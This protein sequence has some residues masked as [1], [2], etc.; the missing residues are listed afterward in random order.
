MAYLKEDRQR[1][2]LA[3]AEARTIEGTAALTGVP[4]PTL[5][6]WRQKD[7]W[8][9]RLEMEKQ[10]QADDP[11]GESKSLEVFVDQFDIASEDKEVLKQ[12]K[13][14]EGI[15][16]RCIRE[17]VP[18]EIVR[19]QPKTFKEAVDVM[20]KCWKTREAL[21]HRDKKPSVSF[22]GGVQKV[23]FTTIQGSTD[24]RASIQ[25]PKMVLEQAPDN[26]NDFGSE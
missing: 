8:L 15:C 1:A 17:E 19:L 11:F 6:K 3:F 24:E 12:I 26:L 25:K 18:Q 4:V 14:I 16:L 7:N 2:Y 9:A 5:K 20:E 21:L 23:D 22:H 10:R 13:T